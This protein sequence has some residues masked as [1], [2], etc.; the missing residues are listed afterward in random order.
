[1]SV[2]RDFVIG[3]CAEACWVGYGR[4]LELVY[5]FIDERNRMM[6]DNQGLID[7]LREK[8][9]KDVDLGRMPE[10]LSTETIGDLY[11]V[12]AMWSDEDILY[13]L[14]D[15]ID[16]KGMA[17]QLMGFMETMVDYHGTRW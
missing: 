1:M 12:A 9:G 4:G 17:Q 14:C 5:E 6:M 7:Y 8:T 11:R 2:T 13:A 10:R 16:D 3:C 15:Y